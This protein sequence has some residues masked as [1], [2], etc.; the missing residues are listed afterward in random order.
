MRT[1]GSSKRAIAPASRRTVAPAI[2]LACAVAGWLALAAP[3]LAL[4]P[5]GAGNY[6]QLLCADPATGEGL[7]TAGMPEGLTNPASIDTWQ[8]S[9]TEVDCASGAMTRAR[10]VPMAVG[11]GNTYPQ[12]TWSA[13]L[14]QAP[15]NVSINGGS[16]Y[17][18]ERAE[19]A[20]S[21]FMG[22][23]QQGGEYSNLYSLPR[24]SADQGDWFAGNVA[25]RGTFAWPFS[26]ENL[27]NLTI[28]S[29]AAHWDVNATCDSNGNNNS[30]C[31]LASGQW[32]YRIFGGEISLRANNDP[33]AA[34]ISGPIAAESP[35]R[36]SE[37]VTFSAT[38]QGPGLAYVKLV[39]DGST[40]Q[41][42][43][44]DPN[45]GR[46][47]PVPGGDAYTWA[48]QVPCKTSLGARTYSFDTTPLPDGSHHVQVLLE[49]AAGNQSLVVDRSVQTH[50]APVSSAL[51]TILA[52]A[53][54][55]PG[56]TLSA[57]P[58]TWSAPSG[59]GPVSYAYQWQD[60]DLQGNGCQAIPGAQSAGY[61]AGAPDAGH[62]LRVSVT[63]S[64]SDGATVAASAASGAVPA[65][66]PLGALPG[67][68]SSP[69][70]TQAPIVGAPNGS[71]AS[72]A[73]RMA[74]SGPS[75]LSRT[76]TRRAF[77]LAGRLQDSR[78]QP[79]AKAGLD[80]LE[81]PAGAGAPRILGHIWSGA[82]GSFSAV[83]PGGPTRQIVLGYR[84]FWGDPGYAA[85]ASIAE[86]VGAG[87]RL[88][89]TPRRTGSTGTITLSGRVA[90]PIP[91]Q[92]VVVALLVHYRGRWE[93][94]RTPRTDAAGR[95]SIP[96][97][98][99][100]SV[101]RFPFRAT[102]FGGQAGLPYAQGDSAPVSVNTG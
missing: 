17:R 3:A 82:D 81:I 100:G 69:G 11:Q 57:A 24:N 20:N 1:P 94:F 28:S 84:A 16:I 29:D 78:G 13:L 60:C 34:N 53:A 79:I 49:D 6:T 40:V 61:T 64:D 5:N 45:N 55:A 75:S 31:T 8:I 35:L 80:M 22:I 39:I 98:F 68:G 2:G 71:G 43:G 86:T 89:I 36:G 88:N 87:V 37:P 65:P 74:L 15:A 7:G 32:E 52:P 38:D 83:V 23:I 76:F 10:G 33:Q 63:A 26:P 66:E 91:R 4:P 59:A 48:Y 58:G 96:Y 70:V 51:P 67:P 73:A 56:G 72:E 54:L 46:C 44:I 85:Q 41:S 92:G 30:S 9:S 93:P 19:G 101:G 14:Y 18:A 12:G 90:G 21:G 50:N 77:R 99:Q 42:Q 25:A 47:V 62:T 95:F 102:V 27:V 97:Q